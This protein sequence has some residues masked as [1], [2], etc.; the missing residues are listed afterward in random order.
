MPDLSKGS[1]SC[2]ASTCVVK[3]GTSRLLF[4]YADAEFY[5]ACYYMRLLPLRR[6]R[7]E[8]DWFQ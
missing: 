2:S 8:Y 5:S 7:W 4:D 3:A 1:Q 6:C